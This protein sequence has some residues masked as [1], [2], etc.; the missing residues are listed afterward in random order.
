M[1]EIIL[2]VSDE[3][4]A[5]IKRRLVYDGTVRGI[6]FDI[7]EAQFRESPK[8]TLGHLKGELC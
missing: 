5:V 8:F 7:T 4:F 1:K 2:Q 3:D 6:K